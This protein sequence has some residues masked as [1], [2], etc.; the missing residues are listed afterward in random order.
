M[1]DSKKTTISVSE[2]DGYIFRLL[3]ARTGY[4]LDEIFHML[5]TE[6]KTILTEGI[7]EKASRVNFMIDADLKN[8]MVHLRFSSLYMGLDNLNAEQRRDVLKAFDYGPNFE[9]LRDKPQPEGKQR[10]EPPQEKKE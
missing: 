8:S 4:T 10:P 7:D 9:D 3:K 6:I 2:E 5:A 1:S